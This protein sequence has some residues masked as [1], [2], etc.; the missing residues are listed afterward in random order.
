M[1]SKTS[2][3]VAPCASDSPKGKLCK[4]KE[5]GKH[6]GEEGRI[7]APL[8]LNRSDARSTIS[9]RRRRRQKA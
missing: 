9:L 2:P 7:S 5:I 4:E 3:T 6:K 1:T 8:F